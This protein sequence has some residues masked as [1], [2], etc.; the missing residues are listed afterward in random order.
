MNEEIDEIESTRQYIL[1]L[2]SAIGGLEEVKKD[3]GTIDQIYCVGDE[4]L[5]KS[6]CQLARILVLMPCLYSLFKGFEKSH[7]FG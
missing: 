5:G 2:C 7:S 6:S 4:S 3:D 1:T